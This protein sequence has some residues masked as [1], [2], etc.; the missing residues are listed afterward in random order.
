MK[1]FTKDEGKR[2]PDPTG[3]T[4]EKLQDVT[5]DK[6]HLDC[7][8]KKNSSTKGSVLQIKW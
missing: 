8:L 7:N 5:V 4:K 1:S 3:S 2:D 6:I